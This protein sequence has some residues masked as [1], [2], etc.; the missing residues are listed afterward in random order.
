MDACMRGREDTRARH[1][2]TTCPAQRRN[3]GRARQLAAA[4]S[5][6]AAPPA[7]SPRI[8]CLRTER[9]GSKV[10]G[11]MIR[12]SFACLL[13]ATSACGSPRMAALGDTPRLRPL[14]MTATASPTPAC[15]HLG[16]EEIAPPGLALCDLGETESNFELT[17]PGGVVFARTRATGRVR[18]TSAGA[19]AWTTQPGLTLRGFE[20][21]IR[22]HVTRPLVVGGYLVPAPGARHRWL[23]DGGRLKIELEPG[24]IGAKYPLT[25]EVGCKD[26]ALRPATFDP[27]SVLP[28]G[29]PL[30]SVV[31]DRHVPLS[32]APGKPPVAIVPPGEHL[33]EVVSTRGQLSL[34]R[35]REH[36]FTF[37]GWVSSSM[38]PPD[39]GP[40][41]RGN[42]YGAAICCTDGR[43][44]GLSLEPE[45]TE[46]PPQPELRELRCSAPVRLV[47]DVR[48]E[49]FV[50]GTL[51]APARIRVGNRDDLLAELDPRVL[52]SQGVVFVE[53]RVLVP[54]CDLARCQ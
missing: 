42:M 18:L 49:R 29:E 51:S 50:A 16:I 35:G 31:V 26:V 1:A 7:R 34:L 30:R 19:F 5:Y 17:S 40:D 23:P 33:L 46:A 20:R 6:A 24:R 52:S 10:G 39:R 8:W 36:D 37:F 14:G 54:T 25:A 11:D 4:T 48:G 22:V 27:T 47:I 2:R 44:S 32:T 21:A 9:S 3:D 53:G 41:R 28:H 13:V 15:A 45:P 12:A 43:V 38:L